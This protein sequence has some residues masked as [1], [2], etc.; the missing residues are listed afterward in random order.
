MFV[1][2]SWPVQS[3]SVSLIG[4]LDSWPAAAEP[5]L[6]GWLESLFGERLGAIQVILRP[7]AA[8]ADPPHVLVFSETYG[9]HHSSIEYGNAVLARLAAVGLLDLFV[10]GVL[11]H[12]QHV[13]E[14]SH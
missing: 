11:G 2:M 8:Q 13:I 12:A 10:R 9:F 5:S 1:V 7:A 6:D 14:V 3:C 4:S